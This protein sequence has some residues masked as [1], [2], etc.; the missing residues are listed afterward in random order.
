MSYTDTS[1]TPARR[2]GASAQ[3]SASQRLCA[4]APAARSSGE[5][6]AERADATQWRERDLVVLGAVGEQHFGDDAVELELVDAT[7]GLPE[8]GTSAGR[9]PRRRRCRSR[10]PSARRATAAE[11]APAHAPQRREVVGEVFAVARVEVLAVL[12]D[13]RP[14]V[15]V[16]G[17]EDRSIRGDA[18]SNGSFG[19]WLTCS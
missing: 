3:K 2:S 13:R 4:C 14:G 6:S 17:D 8:A 9:A 7:V 19:Y 15:A 12:L 11:E 18:H 16:G 10:P 5:K 1:A